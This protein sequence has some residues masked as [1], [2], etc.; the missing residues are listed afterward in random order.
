[1]ATTV[2]WL[3]P[4][5]AAKSAQAATTAR[6]S[7][8]YQCPT[9]AEAKAIMRLV[10]TPRVRKLSARMKQGI[11]MISNFSISVKNFSATASSGTYVMVKSKVITVRPSAMEIGIPVSMR[12]SSSPKNDGSAHDRPSLRCTAS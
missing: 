9:N 2:A 7:P 10:T 4:E 5:T 3:E 8:P 11:A 6:P 12:A 1:M